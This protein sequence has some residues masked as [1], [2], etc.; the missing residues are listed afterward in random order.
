M[1]AAAFELQ[2]AGFFGN[3]GRNTLIG[4]GLATVDASLVKDTAITEKTSFQF[5]TEFFDLLN[6]PNFAT[7]LRNVLSPAGII[8][9]AGKITRTVTTSRQIQF[10]AKVTF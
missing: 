9:T 4:P 10:G 8:P 3:V 7:P 6:H 1:D 5:R 2:P